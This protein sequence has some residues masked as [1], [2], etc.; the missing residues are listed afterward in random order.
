[1]EVDTSLEDKLM[2][3]SEAI[4]GF[5]TKIVDLEVRTTPSTPPE[6]RYQREKTIVMIVESIKSLD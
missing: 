2:N 1:M 5:H 4:H 6:E 3:I